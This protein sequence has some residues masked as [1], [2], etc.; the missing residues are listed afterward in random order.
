MIPNL[1]GFNLNWLLWITATKRK[2][3]PK[4]PSTYSSLCMLDTSGKLLKRFLK[5]RLTAANENSGWLSA[6]QYGFGPGRFTIY[7]L[8]EMTEI[9]LARLPGNNFL[10]P[11]LVLAALYDKNAFNSLIWSNILNALEYNFSEQQDLMAMI[12]VI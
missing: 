6:A 3:D 12:I 10:K 11:V 4:D 1:H 2:G 9:A 5:P 7:T 8:S